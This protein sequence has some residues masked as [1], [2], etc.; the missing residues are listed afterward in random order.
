MHVF[1]FKSSRKSEYKVSVNIFTTDIVKAYIL[2]KS[3][4][5]RH[6]VKGKPVLA[7]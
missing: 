3:Y 6:N 2:C 4:F 7:I 5:H 1:F